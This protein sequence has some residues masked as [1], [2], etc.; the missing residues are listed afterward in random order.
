MMTT[1][2]I[3]FVVK[4][5]WHIYCLPAHIYAINTFSFFTLRNKF[6]PI[7]LTFFRK[8]ENVIVA[9]EQ[10]IIYDLVRDACYPL[11]F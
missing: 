6:T 7:S 4:R 8:S 1:N 11:S 10:I 5:I 9:S 3:L 2:L